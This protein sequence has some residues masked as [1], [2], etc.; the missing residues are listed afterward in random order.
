V[1]EYLK[2]FREMRNRCYNLTIGEKDLADLAFSGLSSYLREKMEGQNFVHVNQ[3]LQRTTIHENRARDQRSQSQ[4]RDNNTRDREKQ[5][6]NSVDEE[7]SNDES[8]AGIYVA[9]WLDMPKNKSI[10]CPFLK[11]ISGRKT[12]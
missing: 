4:F 2:R 5:G 8:D 7:A 1:S 11:P 12:K 6:M 3:V 10:T 9:E